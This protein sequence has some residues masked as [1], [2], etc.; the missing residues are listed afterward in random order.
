M[1]EKR[2]IC[3]A[4]GKCG[5]CQTLNMSY[6]EELSLKMKR[7][8]ELL[9]R[10][11]HVAEILPSPSDGE[12]ERPAGYRNKTQVLLRYN[13]GRINM[14]LYRSSDGGLTRVE[15]C[16]MEAPELFAAAKTV[17]KLLDPF[18]I[19]VWDGRNGTLRHV[20]VRK[21][22]ATGEVLCAL[23]TRDGLF[24]GAREFAAE[25]VKR[26]PEI[27][28][29]VVT[30]NDTDTPL[31][32]NGEEYALIG[33]GYLTDELCG[34]RFRV[35]A[36]A[37]YQ[38]NPRAA[39]L[40]YDKAAEFA[41]AGADTRI[42][43]AYCGIGTVGIIAAKKGCASLEGFDVNAESIAVAAKNAEENGVGSAVF[44]RKK[45]AA[46]LSL[47]KGK[48]DVIFADP[49]RAGC[50]GKFLEAVMRAEPERFVYISCNPETL[51]RDLGIL[52]KSFRI[53]AIQPV[54]LF[55]GTYHIETVC[56]LYHQKKDFISVP[57]EPKDASYMKTML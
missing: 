28:S 4:F 3:P 42:L 39:E 16:P 14:G 29:V 9:K 51:A 6:E 34:C 57:Y 27:V 32:M 54:D 55:P 2:E 50:D 47:E 48:Y 10:F 35:P 22:F 46:F 53:C 11:G 20:T 23:V 30:S 31:Y 24:P 19:K 41:E 37:F 38:I 45:D 49:P 52:K 33:P 1:K 18:K 40:L 36:K 17:R 5:A 43:D 13:G 7:E 25:L 15:R 44:S 12:G 56:C 26:H 21:G 8:I